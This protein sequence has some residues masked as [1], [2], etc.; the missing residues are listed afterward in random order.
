MPAA[1]NDTLPDAASWMPMTGSAVAPI[2]RVKVPS[3][4]VFEP[5]NDAPSRSG[6]SLT[7]TAKFVWLY[8]ARN[9]AVVIVPK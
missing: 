3:L 6:L 9:D 1:G 5:E 4:M 8:A 7:L 2:L